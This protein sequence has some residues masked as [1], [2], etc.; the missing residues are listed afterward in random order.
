MEAQQPQRPQWLSVLF[1]AL[2][3]LMQ[4][5][6]LQIKIKHFISCCCKVYLTEPAVAGISVRFIC[7]YEIVISGSDEDLCDL[8]N[9]QITLDLFFPC[10]Q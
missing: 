4:L 6:T 1:I 9:K 7:I 3:F 2:G 10:K 8:K 5:F